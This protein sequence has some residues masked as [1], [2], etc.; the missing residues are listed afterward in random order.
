[1]ASRE[2][3]WPELPAW[4]YGVDKQVFKSAAVEQRPVEG[5][6][7]GT[8]SDLIPPSKVIFR[9]PTFLRNSG[10][11]VNLALQIRVDFF[12]TH[13]TRNAVIVSS[14]ASVENYGRSRRRLTKTS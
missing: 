7:F 3:K 11:L 2:W 5:L 8:V 13:S 10:D 14:G 12:R 1:L 9:E 4:T 6:K